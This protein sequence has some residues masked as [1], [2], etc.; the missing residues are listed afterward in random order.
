MI[1]SIG[2]DVLTSVAV[3]SSFFWVATPKSPVKASLKM[4]ATCSSETSVDFQR[5]TRRYI[6][7]D[8]PLRGTV[9]CRLNVNAKVINFH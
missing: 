4:K 3:K 2:F 5:T 6:P 8:R 1:Q 9:S 7:E